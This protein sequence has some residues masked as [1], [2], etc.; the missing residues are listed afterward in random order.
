MVMASGGGGGG[1][2]AAPSGGGG[3]VPGFGHLG[4]SLSFSTSAAADDEELELLELQLSATSK[5]L[6]GTGRVFQ[7]EC[8]DECE[9]VAK[10]RSAGHFSRFFATH[11]RKRHKQRSL[12]TLWSD[13][14]L[15]EEV[16]PEQTR[17][18]LHNV[19][20]NWNFNAFTLDRLSSGR[21]L[22][23]LCTYLF[24]QND[25][26]RKFPGLDALTVFKFFAMVERGYHSTNPYH[27]NVHAADVTQAMACF[28]SEP[29][30]RKH[31]TPLEVMASLV[32]AVCHDVDH[33]GFN[34]KFLIASSSHL[35]GLYHNASVLE[36]HHWRTA[37]SM[38]RESG[39]AD[40]L[41]PTDHAKMQDIIRNLILATDIA[42]QAEFL[43][44][45]RRYQETGE[46]DL[47]REKYRHFVLQIAVKCADI[48]NPCRTWNISRL[49]SY[50]A[51]E[52]FFRQGDRERVLGFPISIPCD[53]NGA[54]VAKI[55]S[56][57]YNFIARPL[58]EEWNR[59]VQ[60]TLSNT[61]INILHTNLARW[62]L[63]IKEEDARG[64]AAMAESVASHASSSSSSSG[65]GAGI[66]ASGQGANASDNNSRRESLEP[67][68]HHGGH[69]HSRS[70]ND[71]DSDPCLSYPY[72]P[73]DSALLLATTSPAS[74]NRRYSLPVL[75]TDPKLL[76]IGQS[77]GGAVAGTSEG[78]PL[79]HQL[80]RA[81][82][83]ERPRRS[84]F[85]HQTVSGV[86]AQRRRLFAQHRLTISAVESLSSDGESGAGSPSSNEDVKLN[87]QPSTA[88]SAEGCTR[89]VPPVESGGLD[90]TAKPGLDQPRV[91]FHLTRTSESS[92]SETSK[93]D[94]DLDL[95]RCN[96][97]VAKMHNNLNKTGGVSQSSEVT[98]SNRRGSA[99]GELLMNQINSIAAATAA[100]AAVTAVAAASPDVLKAA[101]QRNRIQVEES[102]CRRGSL[103]TDLATVRSTL[104]QQSFNKNNSSR[105][106]VHASNKLGKQTS[107]HSRPPSLC[108]GNPRASSFG[109]VGSDGQPITDTNNYGVKYGLRRGSAPGS[110]F[111]N[112]SSLDLVT[113]LIAQGL[114]PSAVDNG[115]HLNNNAAGMEQQL[116]AQLSRVHLLRQLASPSLE[117]ELLDQVVNSC[118]IANH[119]QQGVGSSATDTGSSSYLRRG[120]L[121]TELD[122]FPR[123]TAT[124]ALD[125]S[126]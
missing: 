64:L 5:K 17:R 59:L 8:G 35:A 126:S 3:P 117:S 98:A 79:Q 87:N 101:A 73:L 32:A 22:T 74:T 37:I 102:S 125:P 110:R 14:Q 4:H 122:H 57:F 67:G 51:C 68:S 52:E 60:S 113:S 27:N 69:R 104:A 100:V 47:S 42:R 44:V 103:P 89:D 23:T 31:L 36:N 55:Q 18:L 20:L 58:F 1:S 120:S 106:H 123:L 26:F 19:H 48:S 82:G 105:L 66:A 90:N 39:M 118:L 97:Q 77:G 88:P 108:R 81:S 56:G 49:W 75:V 53:R 13:R 119:K 93:D 28:L 15:L 96:R 54:S 99:P 21:S 29:L 71:D 7:Y 34:E 92:N 50:R 115:G 83:L 10:L 76:R 86:A 91:S 61:M 38:M 111:A 63:I 124:T 78:R 41:D 2:G 45:L 65:G 94:F 25:L 16:Q 43:S 84:S 46:M 70:S 30:L 9:E 72:M 62:E 109:G 114:P 24:A 33:P 11:P 95:D 12:M 80:Y 85:Q 112:Q 6:A 116:H 107:L 121:P 40:A